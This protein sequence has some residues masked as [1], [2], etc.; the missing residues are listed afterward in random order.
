MTKRTPWLALLIVLLPGPVWA[1]EPP[2]VK[3]GPA[4]DHPKV[5]ALIKISA[6]ESTGDDFS[7]SFEDSDSFLAFGKEAAFVATA[8]GKYTFRCIASGIVAGKAKIVTGTFVLDVE[9]QAPAPTPTPVPTPTPAPV[10]NP[11]PFPAPDPPPAP[12]PTPVVTGHL[13][14]TYVAD[15]SAMASSDPATQALRNQ[16]VGMRRDPTIEAALQTYDASFKWYENNQA[17]LVTRRLD[18][19]AAKAGYPCLIIQQYDQLNPKVAPIVGEP[20]K[21][22][23]P[24]EVAAKLKA[25]RGK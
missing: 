15:A 18:G 25:L 5:G 24:A 7:W 11:T 21:N 3:F 2:K 4:P 16:M 20:M 9:G 1:Q 22:P 8:P 17:G 23:T 13:L 10:P 14:L 6:I 19:I 12:L